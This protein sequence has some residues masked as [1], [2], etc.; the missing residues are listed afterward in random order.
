M[1]G[2]RTD[3]VGS[4]KANLRSLHD[5]SG[6]RNGEDALV[7][8]T[9]SQVYATLA[10]VEQQRIANILTVIG[11]EEPDTVTE[12]FLRMG[13]DQ[14]AVRADIAAALGWL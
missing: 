6:Y 12:V 7:V 3:Y 1:S 4:A 9:I 11:D 10:L 5:G 13:V 14:A 8:A 2:K